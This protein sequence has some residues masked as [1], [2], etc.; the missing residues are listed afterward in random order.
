MKAYVL[1]T[2]VIFGL[3]TLA[4]FARML[5]EG[6]HLAT[7]PVFILLTIAAAALCFWACY[8]LRRSSRL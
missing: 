6:S 7:D 4:H 2:G 5:A 1:I 8:L 3:I